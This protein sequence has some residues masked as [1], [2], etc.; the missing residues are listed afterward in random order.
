MKH[1]LAPFY[2]TVIFAIAILFTSCTKEGPAGAT[3]P[4]GP[5][6]P[7]GAAGAPGVPGAPGT[8]GAPGAPGT[9]NV[10]YSAWLNVTFKGADSTGWEAE[11]PAPQLV[12]SIL[13]RGEIKVYCN[14]GS[15][16]T[17]AK[18]VVPLP[19]FDL[20]LF[21]RLVTMN[22][23]FSNQAITLISNVNLSSQKIRNFNYLQYRYILIP[24]G[25]AAR[26][27]S[28][29]NWDKYDEVKKYLRLN[30]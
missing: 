24:G 2:C 12:D 28:G 7:T 22:P 30:D 13:N 4:A 3:G 16:S 25:K 14:L 9:A 20:F 18:F 8:P 6:G 5:A 11:V 21:G 10:V 1:K 15:D 27:A 23:Y 17:N 26:L 29:I 19:M